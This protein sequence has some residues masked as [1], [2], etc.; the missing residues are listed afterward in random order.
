MDTASYSKR[1]NPRLGHYHAMKQD[2]YHNL[3][4][5]TYLVLSETDKVNNTC[6]TIIVKEVVQL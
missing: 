3:L 1:L 4:Q 5:S 6:P 2:H